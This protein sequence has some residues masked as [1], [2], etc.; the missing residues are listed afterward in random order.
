MNRDKIQSGF[1]II[2]EITKEYYAP[3][4]NW[5]IRETVRKAMENRIAKF[6]N[7]SDAIRFVQG[8]LKDQKVDL[9]STNVISTAIKQR[10]I[11][12]FFK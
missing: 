10:K 11:E 12:D 8:R 1:I 4:G 3:V 9:F 5:H 2:R 6:D 7:L